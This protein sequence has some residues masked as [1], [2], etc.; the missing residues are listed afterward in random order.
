LYP[1]EGTPRERCK[2]RLFT[3]NQNRKTLCPFYPVKY[4]SFAE[5]INERNNEPLPAECK[6]C[7]Y[8]ATCHGG[9][10]ASRLM[11]NKDLCKKDP[12]CISIGKY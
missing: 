12:F 4:S 9:C 10:P 8:E 1:Q 5:V 7:K 6:N 3:S 11:V 2:Q